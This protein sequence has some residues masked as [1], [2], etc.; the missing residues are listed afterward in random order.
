[1][2]ESILFSHYP[3][4]PGAI[5]EHGPQLISGRHGGLGEKRLSPLLIAVVE[6]N[7]SVLESL[8]GL[9]QSAGYEALLYASGE[10]FLSSGSLQDIDCLISDIGLPG[11]NGIELVRLVLAQ[12][13]NLPAIIVTAR[14]E[15]AV[16]KAALDAGARQVFLKP[17]NNNQL[18]IAIAAIQ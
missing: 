14:H 2:L 13:A 5:H 6:D 9:L 4:D 8:E 1:L 12:R 16:L 17:L 10:D 7:Q 11:I 18:L 3:T 15:E